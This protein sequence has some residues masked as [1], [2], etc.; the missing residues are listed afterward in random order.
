M[1][2]LPYLAIFLAGALF[3]LSAQAVLAMWRNPTP[4]EGH[5]L[6]IRK[7]KRFVRKNPKPKQLVE[8]PNE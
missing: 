1:T 3:T 8:V 2:A 5:H 4:P 6:V 7:G